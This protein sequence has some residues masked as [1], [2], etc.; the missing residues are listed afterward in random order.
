M[1]YSLASSLLIL[2][3]PISLYLL[4]LLSRKLSGLPPGPTPLPIIG[5]LYLISPQVHLSLANLAHTYGP[6]MSLRLGQLT[7]V[8][9]SS[10]DLAKEALLQ[11]DQAFNGRFVPD[12]VRADNQHQMGVIWQPPN[13]KWRQLRAMYT[14]HI[15]GS[16]SLEASSG[17]RKRKVEELLAFLSEFSRAGRQVS[18]RK[19]VH[20]TLNNIISNIEFSTDIVDLRSETVGR[21]QALARD[22]NDEAGRPNVSDFFPVLRTFDPQGNRRRVGRLMKGLYLIF[23]RLIE[24]RRWS[25]NFTTDRKNDLLDALL[26]QQEEKKEDAPS[27]EQM[28]AQFVVQLSCLISNFDEGCVHYLFDLGNLWSLLGDFLD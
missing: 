11:N 27:N 12:A 20:A 21:F 13:S 14:K 26:D 2:L 10:V 18:V 7:T 23:D 15:F 28:K 5:N 9:I 22:L 19:L 17:I 3:L 6:I 24:E 16:Q 1:D 25:R 8:V 4:G